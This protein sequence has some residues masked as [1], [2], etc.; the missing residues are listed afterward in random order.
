AVIE[1]SRR[2]A[3]RKLIA[4]DYDHQT[5]HAAKN[6]RPAPA[7]GWIKGL[8]ARPDGIWGMVDWTGRAAEHLRKRE[9][10]YLSPAFSHSPNGEVTCLLRAALTNNP[11]LE[12]TA[13]ASAGGTI[14]ECDLSELR[15]LLGL[16]AD[17]GSAAGEPISQYDM[18]VHAVLRYCGIFG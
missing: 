15:Q 13:L 14:M 18:K 2:Y 12:L 1:A 4:I 7:A 6:G 10:R 5:D 16:P 9:Y 3:G 8:Q 17:G 11:N